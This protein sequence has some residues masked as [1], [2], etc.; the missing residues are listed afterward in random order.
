MH[1]N[2][3]AGFT[4][5]QMRDGLAEWA[6]S[7]RSDYGDWVTGQVRGYADHLDEQIEKAPT[8][9]AAGEVLA[10][11]F[12]PPDYLQSF[13]SELAALVDKYGIVS[14]DHQTLFVDQSVIVDRIKT[15]MGAG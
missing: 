10:R 4:R 11:A 12:M 2:L 7:A 1:P 6:N 13:Y 9:Q 3:F 15:A 8:D 14:A 5:E